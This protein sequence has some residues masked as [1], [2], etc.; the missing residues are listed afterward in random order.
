V[1][2]LKSFDKRNLPIPIRHIGSTISSVF[3]SAYDKNTVLCPTNSIQLGITGIYIA[4]PAITKFQWYKD[5]KPVGN[6]NEYSAKE[7]GSYHLKMEQNGCTYNSDTINVKV[8][9]SNL[10]T[11]TV[12]DLCEDGQV[13][14]K[15][16][17][18]P[19][20]E[21][22]WFQ[23]IDKNGFGYKVYN[24]EKK[25]VL[26]NQSSPLYYYTVAADENLCVFKSNSVQG[27]GF[28]LTQQNLNP[29]VPNIACWGDSIKISAT[30]IAGIESF[31]WFGPRNFK[32]TGQSI[33]IK[34]FE[35]SGNFDL[36]LNRLD[37]NLIMLI[38]MI[39][40]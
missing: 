30:N 3:P 18:K 22:S 31:Q 6:F 14:F 27:I 9:S 10:I 19:A 37:Y 20:G 15:V 34:K 13:K 2:N 38:V 29:N 36:Q 21:F 39:F 7:N 1:I 11:P 17:P 28:G 35:T 25:E 5:G 26:I 12:K 4:N 32:G 16:S 33:K 23:S 40:Q 8:L 24:S